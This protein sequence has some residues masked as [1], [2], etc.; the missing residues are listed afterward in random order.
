MEKLKASLLLSFRA[1]VLVPV[2]TVMV[3]L[4]AI[5]MWLINRRI[6]AQLQADAAQQV[7]VAEAAFRN[8][9]E[10]RAS[11]LLRSYR[12]MVN[13]PRVKAV[14]G[15]PHPKTLSIT[16][17][18]LIAEDVADVVIAATE[19][20][21]SVALETQDSL[22][23]K[24]A[25]KDSCQPSITA[26]LEGSVIVETIRH[27]ERLFDIVSLPVRA[28]SKIV[29]AITF[30]IENSMAQEFK[31]GTLNDLTLIADGKVVTSTLEKPA[32][33]PALASKF[34]QLS[35]PGGQTGRLELQEI[36]LDDEHYLCTAGFLDAP[37]QEHQFGYLILSSYEK[38]LQ[39]LQATQRMILLVSSLAIV[40]GTAVVCF[41]VQRVTRPLRELR[42]SAEAVGKGDFSRRV[43]VRSPDEC[44]ELAHVFNQ[45][46]LNL[47]NSREQLEMTVDTLKVTQAQLIQS[48]KLSGIGE[49][50]AGVAHEL[51]N[52]LTS[53]MGFSELLKQS[54]RD[55]K[56][57]RH[58]ELIHKNALR[59]Q[60]IVQSLLSFARRHQP[61][62][63]LT[64]LNVLIEAALEILQ[65]QL[66]TSGIEVT[67]SLEPN[68]PQA[69]VDP[70][71][72]QQVLINI[73]NNARQALEG[74]SNGA[75][76]IT[77]ETR[78]EKVYVTIQDDGP[79]ISEE[80]RARIFDPFFTTKEVG[81]G[82]G[83]GLSLC[84]G[85]I[86]EHGG[87]ITVQSKP[88]EGATFVIELPLTRQ[89]A[90]PGNGEQKSEPEQARSYE[91]SGKRVLVIDDEE[92]ILQM[93]REVLAGRGYDVDVACDGVTGLHRLNQRQ[94]D[95][96]L[97]DW[98]MPG[99][100]GQQV[101][102]RLRT[103]NPRLS[104]RLIFITGDMVSD[105]TRK[106]LEAEKKVCLAKPFTLS[107]FTAAISKVMAA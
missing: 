35:A 45:M 103:V 54:N 106:F 92:P 39:A 76:C 104:Q 102:E 22:L 72:M 34:T 12:N 61:E 42:D 13:E 46:V 56:H 9:R 75:I 23:D 59:C 6:T 86:K 67:T 63:K 66:R 64:S 90:P 36:K 32:L 71:Q 94:Y 3:L 43:E 100:N 11:N 50:V 14:A 78:G 15:K 33:Y 97:C 30:G 26:A 20:G 8:S 5:S 49:F 24:E 79:G 82:T 7:A 37:K 60:K 87:A 70:H 93:V 17:K 74:R 62:Q 58:L 38:P 21:E 10:L 81:K 99:M 96:A 98:K 1:K 51:N 89:A 28:S 47:K 52:P 25:F 85:I 69:M 18:D 31:R 83:L 88:G 16:L 55:P 57:Q 68:L 105:K 29:G 95:L 91:G 53:V 2:V 48:E 107:E 19:T 4:V 80:N 73:I 84:Y 41:F 101:Y 27:G 40:F 77:T 65:Y 44:G